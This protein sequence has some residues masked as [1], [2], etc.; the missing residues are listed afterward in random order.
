MNRSGFLKQLI[1]SIAIGKLPVSLTKDFRKIYLLQC[2]VAGF[3]H[4]E[5]MQLLDSMKEGDLLELVREPENEFDNCA[6]A[7]HLQGKKIGFIPSSV[8]EMLSYLL[9]ADALSLFAVITHLEKNSQPWE[10]VA[11]AVYFVQEV[12]KDL[13]AH[14]SY[15]TRIEAPHYRT[16]SKNKNEV[17]KNRSL[18]LDH[19]FDDGNRVINLDTIPAA[20]VEAKNHFEKC[21]SK[22]PVSINK[23]GRFLQI[24]DDG[25]Y[26]YMYEIGDDI[27]LVKDNNG[28]EFMEFFLT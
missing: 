3:R 16:L 17:K 23:P 9:D 14:A 15:L 28:E 27:Q 2:F 19:L 12:N 22:Y 26:T 20:Q 1:A 11:I 21:Y 4:Y 13:P 25:I 6:I 8:N 18:T 24:K 7:L 10:N 5:G